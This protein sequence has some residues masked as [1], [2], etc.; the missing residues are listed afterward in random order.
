MKP[1]SIADASTIVL[2]LQDE[3]RRSEESRYDHRLHAVLLVAQG[4]KCPEVARLLGD[5][6]RAVEYWINRFE[7]E[8]LAGLVE[9]ERTGRPGRLTAAQ[10]DTIGAVLRKEPR[11]VG[12]AGTLWDGKTL[13]AFARN[14]FGVKLGVRQ[15]QR[16]FRQL[17]FRRRK[18]RPMLAQADPE[19]QREH[20]KNSGRS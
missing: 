17:G 5:S 20:K 10:M 1:L 7:S 8:G 9:G 13:S 6:P 16:L 4:M 12:L 3:I 11:D 14:R 19:R 18:P 15:C 2:G